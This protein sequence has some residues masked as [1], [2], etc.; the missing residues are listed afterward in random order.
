[1][2]NYLNGAKQIAAIMEKIRK[3][4][5]AQL[6]GSEVLALRDYELGIVKNPKTGEEKG[7]GLPK[8]NV[9]YFELE[10]DAWCCVRPSGTEPKIKIYYTTLGKDLE[11]AQAKK[12]KFAEA[13]KP[14]MA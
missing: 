9:L 2:H 10:N 12:D 8:S 5:P 14:I 1:M 6:G 4:V 3:E 13:L 11:E 7:T